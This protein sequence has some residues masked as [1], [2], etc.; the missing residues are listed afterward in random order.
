MLKRTL[1]KALLKAAREYPVVTVTGPRQSGKT[2]LLR[3]SF[4]KFAYVSLEEPD[5]RAFASEDPRTFLGQFKGPLL[6]DEVQHVPELLSYVQS[7]VDRRGKPGQ[8]ILSGSQNLLLLQSVS[9]SLA[10]RVSILHLLPLSFS[11]IQQRT[12]APLAAIGSR[13]LS[14]ARI[15][16]TDLFDLL[17]RGQYPRVHTSD[18]APHDWLRNYYQTYV[19]RDVRSIVNVGDW[20][21]FSRFV[22]LCAG[23]N[24]Q[25]L[26]TTSIGNDCGVTHSTVRRWL[27]ILEATFVIHLLRPY[28]RSFSKRMIKAPKLYFLDSGL[29][30]YLL[31]IRRSDELVSHGS[32]GAI[33]ESFVVAEFIKLH[34]HRAIEPKLYFWRDSTGHEVDLIVE[35]GDKPV[36]I[37]IKSGATVASD[38]YDG[39]KY[40]RQLAGPKAPA[41]LIY[42]G[43]KQ[44]TRQGIHTYSWSVL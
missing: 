24:G 41:A 5:Q 6:I 1:Q 32:R 33:F 27:S 42:A 14:D 29:L 22:R 4:P 26:N 37:E 9:Q 15:V 8:F 12:C 28:H 40:W 39:L 19:E 17:W 44:F 30:C 10:G 7:I 16:D 3:E 38:F 2:T 43:D 20:E 34:W 21:S 18:V 36:A 13:D 31:R 11:E 35:F 23:R 25:L